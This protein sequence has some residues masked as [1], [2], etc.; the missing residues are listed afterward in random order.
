MSQKTLIG[1]CDSTVNGSSGCDGCELYQPP[2]TELTGDALKEWLKKWPCYAAHVHQNRL[3]TSFPE[4]YAPSFHHVRMISGRFE[5]A[6]N[7][8][9]L[10]GKVRPDKPWLSGKPR[11]IFVGDM[12]DFLS[13]DVT[14]EFLEHEL[15]GAIRSEKGKRHVWMLLTKRPARLAALSERWGGLP[16]NTIAM[17]TAT[18][19][20]T[21]DLRVPELLKV[22]CKW[23]GLSLEPLWTPINLRSVEI[24]QCTQDGAGVIQLVIV[25]C[26]SGPKRRPMPLEWA[27][28]IRDQCHVYGTSFFLKQVEEDGKVTT[29][30]GA[31]YRQFP[32][33]LP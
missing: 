31:N 7:W 25:G 10:R 8:S 11:H 18:S 28:S 32:N 4:N 3:A 26:E 12:G 23:R 27:R 24:L 16:D 5:Q 21:A 14:D 29:N 17:T 15:L 1:W 33:I 9:D 30:I 13:A 22:R 6:A 19:Q 2:A 20:R